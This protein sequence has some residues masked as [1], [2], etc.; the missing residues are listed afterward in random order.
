[1]KREIIKEFDMLGDALSTLN[2]QFTYR[3]MNL[4]VKA[5]P[6]SLLSIEAMIEGELQKLEACAQIGQEDDY[7]FQI[8]PNYDGDIPALAKA[9]FKDHPEFKQEMR[10]MQVD[11]SEDENNSDMQDVHYINVTMPEVDDNRYDVLKNGVNGF[12]EENKAQMEAVSAKYDAKLATLLDG[13]SDEDVKKV[14]EARDKQTK[15]WYEQRD[16]IYNDKLKEI[17][18][19]HGKWLSQQKSNKINR[20]NGIKQ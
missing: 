3:L 6:V 8:Y 4:C 2:A 11:I 18:E 14:K 10:T 5:E 9:I 13:E 17:E 19:A 20:L 12:Y 15:T 7:S 1:M 16:A